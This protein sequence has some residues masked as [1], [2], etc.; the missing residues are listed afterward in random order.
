V[1]VAL[2]ELL[3]AASITGVYGYNLRAALSDYW[4]QP[5]VVSLVGMSGVGKS[6]LV[7]RLANRQLGSFTSIGFIQRVAQIESISD[8]LIDTPGLD[9]P[10]ATVAQL[11][12]VTERSDL[13]IWVVDGSRKISANERLLLTSI[14]P[15]GLPVHVVLTNLDEESPQR[16][17]AALERARGTLSH[18]APLSIRIV[19]ENTDPDGLGYLVRRVP[20]ESPQRLEDLEIGLGSIHDWL[21][22][23]KPSP[24]P[25]S[26]LTHLTRRWRSL[27]QV[28]ADAVIEQL[29]NGRING[30]TQAL[31]T[32]AR[33]SKKSCVAYSRWLQET[34]PYAQ[35]VARAGDA[36]LPEVPCPTL[37]ALTAVTDYLGGRQLATRSVLKAVEGWRLEGELQIQRWLDLA[38]HHDIPQQRADFERLEQALSLTEFTL[39]HAQQVLR[40]GQE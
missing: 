40:A 32:L 34:A 8:F 15:K 17:Y 33:L 4:T 38:E 29:I 1:D 37:V 6:S 2:R 3:A 39:A 10:R 28:T 27:I 25:L 24:P 18:I 7:D 35:W 11:E 20:W 19:D 14:R 36:A 12:P 22:K 9:T 21:A 26:T 30:R 16:R 23:N 13:L 31:D 5:W